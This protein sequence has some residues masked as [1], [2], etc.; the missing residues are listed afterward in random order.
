VGKSGAILMLVVVVLWASAPAFACLAPSQSHACCRHM[1]MPDCD[2]ASMGGSASCCQLRVPDTSGAPAVRAIPQTPIDAVHPVMSTLLAPEAR[3]GG[4]M[5]L[6][7]E[8]PPPL[9]L[10]GSSILRI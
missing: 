2:M 7:T 5:P 8:T 3:F 6:I 1:A 9:P 10:T 4:S